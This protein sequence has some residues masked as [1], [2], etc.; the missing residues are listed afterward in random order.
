MSDSTRKVVNDYSPRKENWIQKS[1]YKKKKSVFQ[2]D[3]DSRKLNDNSWVGCFVKFKQK[4]KI[5]FQFK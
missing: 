5:S 3:T 4:T 2:K 1:L